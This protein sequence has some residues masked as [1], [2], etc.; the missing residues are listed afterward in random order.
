[1]Q[2]LFTPSEEIATPGW[3]TRCRGARARPVD[4]RTWSSTKGQCLCCWKKDALFS[5]STNLILFRAYSISWTAFLNRV[6]E[7]CL[8]VLKSVISTSQ[9]IRQPKPRDVITRSWLTATTNNSAEGIAIIAPSKFDTIFFIHTYQIFFAL[10]FGLINVCS[11]L[12]NF[13]FTHQNVLRG[14]SLLQRTRFVRSC[15]V[16]TTLCVP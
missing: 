12:I 1:M 13:L 9:W 11:H 7:C 16:C 15:A 6:R 4:G 3:L 10:I 14:R 2:F 8:L 5:E